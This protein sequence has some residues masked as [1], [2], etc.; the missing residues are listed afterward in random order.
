M[1]IKLI[2]A[3]ALISTASL[4]AQKVQVAK[5]DKKYKEGTIENDSKRVE[6]EVAQ[7]YDGNMHNNKVKY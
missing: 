6:L 7:M 2:V 1:K 4:F 3:L 5:A